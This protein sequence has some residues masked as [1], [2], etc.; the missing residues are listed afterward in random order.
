VLL[1][2]QDSLKTLAADRAARTNAG[3]VA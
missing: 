2:E 1:V 3:S